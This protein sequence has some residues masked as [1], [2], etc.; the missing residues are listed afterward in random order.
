MGQQQ[1]AMMMA[2]QIVASS[3][4]YR[5]AVRVRPDLA[6]F[7]PFPAIATLFHAGASTLRP[8]HAWVFRVT[9]SIDSAYRC[10]QRASAIQAAEVVTLLA[11]RPT[12][13]LG[14]ATEA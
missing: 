10:K 1:C 12:P 11:C 8:Q 4:G 14:P 7:A 9:K 2:R 6:F 13:S 5:Y 3:V